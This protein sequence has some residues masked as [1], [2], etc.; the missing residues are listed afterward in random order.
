MSF[1]KENL[2]IM[3]INEFQNPQKIVFG[4]SAAEKVGEE[5]KRLGAGKVFVV[6][7]ENIEKVGILGKIL[8]SLREKGLDVKL[9]KISAAEPTMDSAN[10]VASTVRLEKF[11]VVI[12]VGGGS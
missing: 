2:A 6:S 8:K 3:R 5:A 4:I 7:D 11:D 9:H 10:A 1:L 12:G